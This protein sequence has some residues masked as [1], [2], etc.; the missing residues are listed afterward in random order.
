MGKGLTFFI[1]LVALN[2]IICFVFLRFQRFSTLS[3]DTTK[4]DFYRPSNFDPT[5]PSVNS[6]S[7][8]RIAK[9]QQQ[10]RKFHDKLFP[11]PKYPYEYILNPTDLC[12]QT[13]QKPQKIAFLVFILSAV[14]NLAERRAIRMTWASPAVQKGNRGVAVRLAF[15]LGTA[16]NLSV[17]A[18]VVQEAEKHNDLIQA[19]FVDSYQN[20]TFKSMLMLKWTSEYCADRVH[21]LLKTDDDMY[22]N[23]A[24]LLQSASKFPISKNVMYGYLFR[25]ANPER[26]AAAKWFVPKSQFPG[27]VFPDYLSG[28]SYVM[29]ADAVSKLYK[30]SMEKP[31]MTM[32]DIFITGIC[33][34]AAGIR[35]L[36]AKGFTYLK[37]PSTGCAFHDAVSGH[38]VSPQEMHKIW[39]ELSNKTRMWQCLKFARKNKAKTR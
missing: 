27:K 26:N 28:T 37:R 31:F 15:L 19:D 23:L 30:A 4:L 9:I 34:S 35:R 20:L 39:K 38:H 13:N 5:D 17:Q 25:K 29:S 18:S 12:E 7:L 16:K 32:E 11:N 21:F 2:A 14:G 1:L 36:Q 8:P 24:N 22:I 10:K 6:T 3:S 33:A